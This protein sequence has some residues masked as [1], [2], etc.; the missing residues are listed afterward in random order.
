MSISLQKE[1]ETSTRTLD[2]MDVNTQPSS[3]LGVRSVV[4]GEPAVPDAHLH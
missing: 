1:L 3:Q 2:D 4:L